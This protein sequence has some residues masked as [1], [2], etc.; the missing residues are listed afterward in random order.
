[1]LVKISS[2][3][4]TSKSPSSSTSKDFWNLLK[5]AQQAWDDCGWD[6][7]LVNFS[8]PLGGALGHPF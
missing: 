5:C 3:K 1:M 4:Q 2:K 6:N 8:D 7:Q